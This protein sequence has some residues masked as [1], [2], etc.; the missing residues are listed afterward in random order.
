VGPSVY[1]RATGGVDPSTLVALGQV[2][3]VLIGGHVR[4]MGANLPTA[5]VA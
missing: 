5:K 2:M 1:V 4:E 3:L